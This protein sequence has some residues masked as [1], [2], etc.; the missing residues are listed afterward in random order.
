MRLKSRLKFVPKG[1]Q[2]NLPELGM[3]K[4]LNGSFNQMADAFSNIVAKNPALAQKQGWPTNRVD[5]ENWLDERECKRMI[6]HGWGEQFVDFDADTP[7]QK[8]TITG[9]NRLFKSAA[10]VVGK[11]KT[12]AAIYADL[13]GPEGKV[14]DKAEAERRAKICVACPAL[15]RTS[16]L[17]GYFVQEAA[18]ELMG[19]FSLLKS[20]DVTTSL[21]DQ[22]GICRACSCP[23]RAKVFITGEVLRENIPAED[24][25][26][27]DPGCWIPG[28]I[29][30]GEE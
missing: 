3:R 16:G 18:R 29:S 8:K 2:L 17:K 26:K 27:L 9:T 14:V 22:L 21:D 20:K 6:A 1:F 19:L 28:E 30:K 4:P 15:D 24:I 5:Q 13:F 12:A 23:M 25:A 10:S 11:V 7:I